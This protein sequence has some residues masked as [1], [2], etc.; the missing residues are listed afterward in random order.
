MSK[1]ILE[2]LTK[3]FYMSPKNQ[4]LLSDDIEQY[5]KIVG[6]PGNGIGILDPSS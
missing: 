6:K 5:I 4:V 1:H 3:N 2:E